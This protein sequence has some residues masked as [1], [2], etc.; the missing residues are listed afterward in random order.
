MNPRE[1]IREVLHAVRRIEELLHR[2]L[3]ARRAH[4]SI[5]VG[6]E[7]VQ[8]ASF[9]IQPGQSKT[10]TAVFSDASGVSHPLSQLPTCVDP[11][12]TMTNITPVGSPTVNDPQ[13]QWTFTC[14]ASVAA[15]TT[16]QLN[17]EGI[18]PDGVTD[19]GDITYTVTAADD[20]QVTISV[21]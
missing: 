19:D 2:R 18:N 1:M 9:N 16:G 6:P 4:V 15:G 14:D 7:N 21:E 8:M 13:F 11:A 12:G 20:T 3:P 5:A 10:L 17:L